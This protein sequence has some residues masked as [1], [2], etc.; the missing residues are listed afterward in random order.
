MPEAGRF[1]SE[2]VMAALRQ[3][4]SEH[5]G[6]EIFAVLHKPPGNDRYSEVTVICRGTTTEVPALISR[7][8]PG[9]MTLHNHP[10]G[11]LKP[12]QQDMHMAT[13][14]GEEGVGSMIVDN[15][16]SRCVVIV[17][18]S[19]EQPLVMVEDAEVL[20]IFGLGGPLSKKLEQYEPREGQA[21]MAA[22][23]T[24]A[25]NQNQIMMVEAGTGTGKSLAYLVPAMLWAKANKRRIVIATKTIALQEQLVYK[26]I[27]LAQ[28]TMRDPPKASLVKGRN[29]YVCLRK[30]ADLRTHQLALFEESERT[31]KK[32]I[33][34]LADWVASSNSG[35]RADLPF[36][37][38][39]DAWE[40]VRSDAD[41]CLGSKCPYFQKAPFYE[42]RRQAAQSHILVVNQALL[43]ADLAVR[44]A[45][46][47]YKASAVIPAYEHIILDEAHSIE[48]I[49]TDHFGTKLSSL[50]LR[51]TLGKFL[52]ASRGNRGLFHR[53]FQA[54]VTDAP[55]WTNQLEKEWLLPYREL[56]EQAL[57]QLNLLNQILQE[58]LNSESSQQKVV[59]L[60]E[61]LVQSGRLAEAQKAAQLLLAS[62][63]QV[64]LLVKNVRRGIRE[65]NEKFMEKT[66]GLQIEIEARQQRLQTSLSALKQFAIR[67]EPNQIHWLELRRRRESQEFTYQVSPLDVSPMLKSALF[68]PFKSVIMTSATLSLGD[69]F[70]FISQRLGL[71]QLEERETRMLALPSPF[72]YKSQTRV[73]IPKMT[74]AP[75]HPQ[76]IQ[77]LAQT[78]LSCVVSPVPG[79]TLV[80]LT[81]Y[82]SLNQL[83]R[84]LEH[85]LAEL[86]VELLVQGKA[87][88]SYLARRLAKGHGVLLGTDSF[89]E[90][91]DL[92]GLALTK[93]VIAKLPFRQ[94]GDPIFEARCQ[95]IDADGRSSFNSYA[96]PLARLKFKQGVGR[97]IRSKT[98][99]GLLVLADNRLRGKS[100]GKRFLSLLE[101]HPIE[102]IEK[103][104]L[105]RQ[106]LPLE[107]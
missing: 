30:V 80:L 59:W 35:D 31:L 83:A 20:D 50:G 23:V 15:Q 4:I 97:L 86:G 72:D 39:N 84:Q 94:V 71:D 28:K 88:R 7:T 9:D 40:A 48:D 82:H 73:L 19:Q 2:E 12:S 103:A 18:P 1:L 101:D 49:A 21:S 22:A 96:L 64:I 98:D 24:Q 11:I 78:V 69:Q 52:S 100:Y 3:D 87:H 67:P 32:E 37:P 76:F 41:M 77:E 46:E 66:S 92:P 17:E 51:Y 26:D 29:N 62:L 89:W 54:A 27:P 65:Q 90:G 36:V 53:L 25:L 102:D 33:E 47:N 105:M 61:T 5:E 42:S 34:D 57:N 75:N 85:P 45:S 81:S 106:R 60:K 107:D 14:F 43:F 8:K 68:T 38:S 70:K 79:G 99:S 93:V 95:S 56:Q 10:S 6:A 58:V 16:V 55:E 63:H 13:L 104:D 44:H 91:I 74:Y